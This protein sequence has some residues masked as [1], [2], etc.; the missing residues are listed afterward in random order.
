MLGDSTRATIRSRSVLNTKKV[1]LED[2]REGDGY[3]EGLYLEK[4]LFFFSF[5]FEPIELSLYQLKF[6]S[7]IED[8]KISF[9]C[10][11]AMCMLLRRQ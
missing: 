3:F 7:R 4:R 6:R 10:F 11:D 5:F 9:H 8:T 2:V 1:T